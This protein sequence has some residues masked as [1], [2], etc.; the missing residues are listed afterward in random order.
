[1][2]D[3]SG[4][5]SSVVVPYDL[6]A[7]DLSEWL[8]TQDVTLSPETLRMVLT[9]IYLWLSTYEGDVVNDV[10]LSLEEDLTA[11]SWTKTPA[12]T[13]PPAVENAGFQ[14]QPS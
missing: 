13:P 1:M 9:C 3:Q 8:S 10:L 14:G 12:R 6:D 5:T 4:R 7:A 2:S 11:H